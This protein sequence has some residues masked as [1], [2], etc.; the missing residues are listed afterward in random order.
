LNAKD[1]LAQAFDGGI[2]LSLSTAGDN[3]FCSFA[4]KA[5]GS[6][7]AKTGRTASNKS[8]FSV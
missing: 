7:K 3:N 2:E 8:Y 4:Q 6:G 5:F 1:I